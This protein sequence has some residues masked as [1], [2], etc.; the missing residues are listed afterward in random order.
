M[1]RHLI[2]SA[3]LSGMFVG[4]AVL[5]AVLPP[6]AS[7][8]SD[9]IAIISQTISAEFFPIEAFILLESGTAEVRQYPAEAVLRAPAVGK[10]DKTRLFV[11]AAV[12]LSVLPDESLT[13]HYTFFLIGEGAKF[14]ATGMQQWQR[15][16]VDTELN[17]VSSLESHLNQDLSEIR[18]MEIE[19]KE[20]TESLEKL[21]DEAS[22]VAAVDE[23][24]DLKM[25]IAIFDTGGDDY[26]E[27]RK[28]LAK[29]VSLGRRMK[30]PENINEH[31]KMLSEQLSQT[32]QATAM[33]DQLNNRRKEAAKASL[34][35]KLGL[36]REMK[37]VDEG[38]LA[39]N[40]LALRQRRRLLES[41]LH[42][43]PEEDDRG[44]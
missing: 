27:D 21:R 38:T 17:T 1:K 41:R 26:K 12:P 33:A 16:K 15:E 30:D 36:I 35:R 18:M 3:L 10:E 44:Y 4:L 25:Q 6:K 14:A 2:K 40:V 32:A 31:L 5:A 29:L 24:V 42:I 22:R 11:G 34:T 9:P 43:T 28:R 8:E 20:V 19:A 37:D 23:I 13:H 7:A 39:R